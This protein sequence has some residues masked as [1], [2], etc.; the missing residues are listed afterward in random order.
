MVYYIS[1]WILFLVVYTVVFYYASC[2]SEKLRCCYV[3]TNKVDNTFNRTFPK[4]ISEKELVWHR[5]LETRIIKVVSGVDWKLQFDNELPIDLE[6]DKSYIIPKMTFH[7]I[8][9]G[10]DNLLLKIT[11]VDT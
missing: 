10:S 6:I 1:I 3:D 8:L 2:T 7:R 11:K 9:K 4:D 5:D